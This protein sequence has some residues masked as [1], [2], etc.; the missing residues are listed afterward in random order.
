MKSKS[1]NRGLSVMMYSHDGFGLGH[2]KRNFSIACRGVRE[3]PNS[4]F[5]LISG[6][7]SL[8]FFHIPRGIDYI[9]LPSIIKVTNGKW[10]SRTLS[11]EQRKFREMR[12]ALIRDSVLIF[13]PDVFLVDYMPTGVW[14]E[15][16]PIL[17][18][19]TTCKNRPKI[20]L[21]LR[22]ILDE[23]EVTRTL[24]K[25]EGIYDVIKLYYDRVFIYG[26]RD[27][28]D[29]A[30]HYGLNDSIADKIKYCGYLAPQHHS[31]SEWLMRKKTQ[32][33]KEQRIL[34]ITG[35][36]HDGYPM[37]RLSIDALRNVYKKTSVRAI[38][39]TGPLMKPEEQNL[40]KQRAEGLPFRIMKS[41]DNMDY[42]RSS[43]LIIT[44][45]GYNTLIDSL[46]FRKN[47]IVIPRKGPSKEQRMRA[48]LFSKKGFITALNPPDETSPS[49]LS[50]II[51]ERLDN[52][53]TSR[54][55][56]DMDGLNRVI[57]EIECIVSEEPGNSL[58]SGKHKLIHH[59]YGA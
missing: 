21:G 42:L 41:G 25:Q 22:D 57:R 2:F 31:S 36:G 49:E 39:I 1:D 18:M 30:N 8:P 44:M 40:I 52:P 23:P 59:K 50:D 46:S 24:W 20:I 37:M 15:L 6:S 3:F 27:F 58:I 19:L 34:V 38:F 4:T 53:R 29:T 51:L 12:A 45:G 35:G 7:P 47:I 54:F 55:S 9:K 48:E 26:C 14:D 32:G 17:Q 43:D 13:K 28:F 5:L 10:N 56:L 16:I 33:K 11:I